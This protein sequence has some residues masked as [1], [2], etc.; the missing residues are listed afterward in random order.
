MAEAGQAMPRQDGIDGR[1]FAGI[2]TAGHR[3]LA[4]V[5]GRESSGLCHADEESQFGP[6]AHGHPD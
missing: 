2:G 5:I 1:G 3:E 6:V 4:A